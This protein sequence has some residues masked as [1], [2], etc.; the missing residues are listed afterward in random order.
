V[1][2]AFDLAGRDLIGEH[3]R[4][5]S[6][7]GAPSHQQHGRILSI[8]VHRWI[9]QVLLYDS[10]HL[11][12]MYSG[13]KLNHP[14][15]PCQPIDRGGRTSQ[16]PLRALCGSVSVREE[17]RMSFVSTQREVL[18]AAAG[19]LQGIGSSMSVQNAAAASPTMGVVH[20]AADEVSALTAGHFGTPRFILPSAPKGLRFAR[21]S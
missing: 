10:H 19:T 15:V 18:T 21:C 5:G 8:A 20:A 1:I 14:F 13:L 4:R 12:S 2:D 9:L 16:Q 6:E 17:E 11:K 7:A 3:H